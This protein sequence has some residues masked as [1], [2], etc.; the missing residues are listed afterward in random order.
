[1]DETEER[2]AVDE[3]VKVPL[4]DLRVDHRYQRALIDTAVRK[5]KR[6]WIEK[7]VTAPEIAHREDEGLFVLDGQQRSEAARQLGYTHIRCHIQ[8]SQ[9]VQWEALEFVAL[10]ANSTS[11]TTLAKHK[12]RVFGGEPVA[13][14]LEEILAEY[15]LSCLPM[16]NPRRQIT[17][18]TNVRWPLDQDFEEGEVVLRWAIEAGLLAVNRIGAEA[19]KVYRGNILGGLVWL[20]TLYA[21]EVD[22]SVVA[23]HLKSQ[24]FAYVSDKAGAIGNGSQRP[25]YGR[26]LRK[27]LNDVAGPLFP[28]EADDSA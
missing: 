6:E 15:N 2:V 23:D 7:R 18:I 10:N 24:D 13:C 17:A 4:S 26:N 28:E 14:K 16:G 20:G 1:M 3:L 5:M 25:T 11:V 12:A 8:P 27:W 19:D 22:A 9:G 21:Y